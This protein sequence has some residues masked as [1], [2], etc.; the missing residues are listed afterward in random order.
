M[1][2][3][4]IIAIVA[5][6]IAGLAL[7]QGWFTNRKAARASR[8]SNDLIKK[9]VAIQERLTQIEQSR[10]HAKKIQSLR[11]KVCAVVRESDRGSW[12]LV[13]TNTGQS[14]ARNVII[15]L[16]DKPLMEHDALPNNVTEIKSIGPMSD[17]SFF[18]CFTRNCHPPFELE[19]TWDDDSGQQGRYGTTLT[20]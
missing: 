13:V 16:D 14:T 19:V 5:V 12:K 4:D 3:S 18:L 20:Y 10:E 8:E 17:I 1:T 15:K 9:Q 7:L 6:C 2:A 11:A